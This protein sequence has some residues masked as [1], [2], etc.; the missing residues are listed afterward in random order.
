MYCIRKQYWFV[1]IMKP[2]S[3]ELFKEPP[4]KFQSITSRSQIILKMSLLSHT[5]SVMIPYCKASNWQTWSPLKSTFEMPMTS[6]TGSCA[7]SH[8]TL[9]IQFQEPRL[10]QPGR[11][12]QYHL[13][14]PLVQIAQNW[15]KS[16]RWR[17]QTEISQIRPIETQCIYSAFEWIWK[18]GHRNKQLGIGPLRKQVH[19]WNND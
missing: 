9:Y 11:G 16:S 7:P 10:D 5:A 2:S 3:N 6:V 13:A 15:W 1:A 19:F 14:W 12:Y 4:L 17:N 18:S 8:F